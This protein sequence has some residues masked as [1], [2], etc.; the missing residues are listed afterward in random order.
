MKRFIKNITLIVLSIV[1]ISL[2]INVA[3]YAFIDPSSRTESVNYL[4]KIKFLKE[5]KN[6]FDT[7]FFGSSM[8]YNQIDPML[9]DSLTGHKSFN[10]GLPACF[11]PTCTKKFNRFFEAIKDSNI[12][13]VF[14]EMQN[15]TPIGGNYNSEEAYYNFPAV[16]DFES[17]F[18]H[19]GEFKFETLQRYV[20]ALLN[21]YTRG[22]RLFFYQKKLFDDSHLKDDCGFFSLDDETRNYAKVRRK[23]FLK[24]P[25]IKNIEWNGKYAYKANRKISWYQNY[26]S[27]VL[28]KCKSDGINVILIISPS[29]HVNMI[30]QQHPIFFEKNKLPILDF[31]SKKQNPALYQVDKFFDNTH[32]NKSGTEL[33]TRMIVEKVSSLD[34][35]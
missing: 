16:Y 23:S 32:L 18:F 1:L 17:I 6:S 30:Y 21:K 8:V 12:K 25:V 5:N 29:S 20:Q 34:L 3:I 9:Y 22:L 19:S 2:A 10:F 28:A 26:L 27:R 4:E 7:V 11:P 35:L 15:L 24:D 33:Y 14:F 13:T 31:T